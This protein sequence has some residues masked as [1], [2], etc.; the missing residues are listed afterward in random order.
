VQF[1]GKLTTPRFLAGLVAGVLSEKLYR[2][3]EL[4]VGL[5]PVQRCTQGEGAGAY[6]GLRGTLR[7]PRFLA[8]RTRMLCV[9]ILGFHGHSNKLVCQS[10]SLQCRGCLR[11]RGFCAVP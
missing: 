3:D 11:A 1:A 5:V 9:K 2:R 10:Q 8:C 4:V 7:V 6:V